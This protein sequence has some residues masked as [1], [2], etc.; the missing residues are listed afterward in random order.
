MNKRKIYIIPVILLIIMA[1]GAGIFINKRPG[2]PV[3]MYHMISDWDTPRP[4]AVSVKDFERQMWYLKKRGYTVIPLERLLDYL[5]SEKP[6]PKKTVVLTFDDGY[7]DMFLNAVPILK[8]YNYPATVFLPS[9]LIGKENIWDIKRG[10]PTATILR[11]EQ[12][13]QMMENNISFQAH[14]CNHV[15]L[16]D[17][18]LS[19]AKKE[20]FNS[21]IQLE[22][23]TKRHVNVFCYPSGKYSSEIKNL[24]QQA[25]YSYAFT[26]QEGLVNK[27]DDSYLLKR[28]RINGT[29]S[30]MDFILKLEFFH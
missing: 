14:T 4:L 15:V 9:N 29:Y 26:T 8:K 30:L 17:V 18:P 19:T 7:E 27:D 6:L 22:E 28:L 12:I 11:Q 10:K 2:V 24:V 5:Q 23:V 25:G 1:I 20:I 3:L 21:K 13:Q 16:T